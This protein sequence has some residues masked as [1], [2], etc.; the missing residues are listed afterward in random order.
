MRKTYITTALCALSLTLQAQDIAS[1]LSAI[2]RN[3][4]ELQALKS[5]NAASAYELKEQNALDAPSVEYSPFF[6]KGASGVASSEMVVSQEFDFPTVYAARAKAGRLQRDVMEKEWMA[7]RQSTL[8]AAKLKCLD[9]VRLEKERG[10]LTERMDNAKELLALFEKKMK[11][12]DAT[13]LELNKISMET[14]DLQT[15]LLQNE[16]DL[17]RARQELLALNANQPLVLDGL[18]YPEIPAGTDLAALRAEILGNDATIH[19]AKA[20]VTASEQ[21]VRVT[22]QGWMPRLSLGYRRNTDMDEASN[23]FLV[24][25]AFPIFSNGSRVKAAKARKAAAML[26]LDNAKVQVESETEAQLQELRRMEEAMRIYDLGLLSRSLG[27]LKKA[28]AAG[29]MS[30]V[31]YYTEVD[32]IYRKWQAYL[33]L[34]NQYQGLWATLGKSRL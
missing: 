30:L 13:S 6:R 9:L 28:V 33:T 20:A 29:S 11:E 23:G 21:E 32:G 24:G 22:G 14:M 4:L 31:D 5:A 15:E 19:S 8:L 12:G 10:I 1:V 26:N 34:E 25:A 27:L 16:T 18:S 3:N 17:R 7:V 2:E